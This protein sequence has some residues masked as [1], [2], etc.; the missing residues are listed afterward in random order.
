MGLTVHLGEV[1]V[2]VMLRVI[3]LVAGVA[4]KSTQPIVAVKM[5]AQVLAGVEMGV[6]LRA[7]MGFYARMTHFMP[8]QDS[9]SVEGCPTV[10]TYMFPF[11]LKD[12]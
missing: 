10:L 5:C 3:G 11:F 12:S 1:S 2:T 6:A 8:C 4:W 7:G 9:L